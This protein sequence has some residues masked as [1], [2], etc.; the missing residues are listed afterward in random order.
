MIVVY[1]KGVFIERGHGHMSVQITVPITTA[2]IEANADCKMSG[3]YED[4]ALVI[5]TDTQHQNHHQRLGIP[6]RTPL[7]WGKTDEYEVQ[8]LSALSWPIRYRVL[9]REGYY[10]D[11]EGKRVYFSTQTS[12]VDSRRGVSEVLMRAAV[13]LLVIAGMGYRRCR[14]APG[15]AFSVGG[16][17]SFFS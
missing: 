16:F 2:V 6:K 10:L 1:A 7:Y 4:G 5:T 12:G 8:E 3:R 14:W 11:E 13:V 15:G 17:E 9:A